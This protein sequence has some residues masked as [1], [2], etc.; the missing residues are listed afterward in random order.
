KSW[1]SIRRAE[2]RCAN[3]IGE[4]RRLLETSSFFSL[5]SKLRCLRL[6]SHRRNRHSNRRNRPLNK[7]SK[8]AGLQSKGHPRRGGRF[9]FG[10]L[11]L[12]PPTRV[13]RRM[14]SCVESVQLRL[15]AVATENVWAS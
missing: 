5:T 8:R 6:Y 14:S 10:G 4:C 12:I 2:H 3:Q 11:Q 1:S 13:A 7:P 15:I 9:R